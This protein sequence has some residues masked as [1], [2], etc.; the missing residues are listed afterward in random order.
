V[1][2]LEFIDLLTRHSSS[3]SSSLQ[4]AQQASKL[5]CNKIVDF[6]FRGSEQILPGAPSNQ[7][8]IGDEFV[9]GLAQ[10]YDVLAP[11]HLPFHHKVTICIRRSTGVQ[12]TPSF[13]L[14][15]ECGQAS[16]PHL[17]TSTNSKLLELPC[18]EDLQK[19]GMSW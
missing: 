3:S 1:D 5:L 11:P 18:F 9:G 7:G 2:L 8:R 16:Y 13:F 19:N 17:Q 10:G 6:L 14:S 4:Q 12:G 15:P